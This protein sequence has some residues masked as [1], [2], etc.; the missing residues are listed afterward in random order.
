MKPSDNP[1]TPP[2]PNT[3][4]SNLSMYIKALLN[5]I[6][7]WALTLDG[8]KQPSGKTELDLEAGNFVKTFTVN[9]NLD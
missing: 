7:S 9:K 3:K 6:V 2:L 5:D 8:K 1:P 4:K